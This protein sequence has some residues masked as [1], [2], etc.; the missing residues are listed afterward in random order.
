MNCVLPSVTWLRLSDRENL[1]IYNQRRSENHRPDY[2][3]AREKLFQ[4]TQPTAPYILINRFTSI[5]R[6]TVVNVRKY[7]SLNKYFG[8]FS[9][10]PLAECMSFSRD[11]KTLRSGNSNDLRAQ[12]KISTHEN[13]NMEVV[14][15]RVTGSSEERYIGICP[16]LVEERLKVSLEPLHAQ[17]S[18]L[19]KMMDWLIQGNL[20]RESM[21][22]STGGLRLQHESAYIEE[23]GSSRFSTV[24]PLTTAGYSP[25][26]FSFRQ[27][28]C[29]KS[30]RFFHIL[31]LS[32]W[33]IQWFL[34]SCGWKIQR[35]RWAPC[36]S[37]RYGIL[38]RLSWSEGC[39][40]CPRNYKWFDDY[41][42]QWKIHW[43]ILWFEYR[44]CAVVIVG[45][46]FFQLRF[47]YCLSE[48]RSSVKAWEKL[49]A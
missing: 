39:S 13:E 46:S 25:D 35:S 37:W 5:L 31:V 20:T 4:F 12:P 11:S 48:H 47:V 8:L 27:T 40:V 17:I 44:A 3:R 23:P 14:K 36:F 38:P 43:V 41:R 42:A 10:L 2:V 45:I 9:N 32:S 16:E 15:S 24:A 7:Y 28:Y 29:R 26:I 19:T 34:R 21:T 49:L 30:I 6:F 1:V 18:P 33:S 22:A